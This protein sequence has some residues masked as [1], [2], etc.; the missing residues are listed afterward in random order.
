MAVLADFTFQLRFLPTGLDL[1][2]SSDR[3]LS[4]V[5][6]GVHFLGL[7]TDLRGLVTPDQYRPIR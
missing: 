1:S 2:Q 6:V 7:F 3:R 4:S 5:G